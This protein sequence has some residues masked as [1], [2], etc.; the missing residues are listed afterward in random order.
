MSRSTPE[1]LQTILD[2]FPHTLCACI[3]SNKN[4]TIA[5]HNERVATFFQDIDMNIKGKS[6]PNLLKKMGAHHT[7]FFLSNPPDGEART[8]SLPGRSFIA[9]KKTLRTNDFGLD[10]ASN[11]YLFFWGEIPYQQGEKYELLLH[12]FEILLDS[13]HD[14]VWIIDGH[15]MTLH[16]NKALNRIAGINAKNVVGK[17]VT[18]PM[19]EGKFT[20]CVTLDAL[21]QKKTVTQF[22]DYSNGNR[23]LNTSVPILDENGEVRRVVASIRDMSELETLQAKMIRAEMEAIRYKAG[24]ENQGQMD[25]YLGSSAIYKDCLKQ[26]AQVAKSTSCVLLTGE[27]GTGKSMA[28]GY[29]HKKSD[30]NGKAFISINCAAIPESLMDSELFGYQKGAFTGADQGGK[31]G[32][33]ELADGGTLLLDEV[34]ELPLSV[35]A[36]LLHVLDNFSF[37]KVG[38]SAQVSVDVRIVAASN[39]PLAKLVKNG[40]FRQD[41]YYRLHILTVQMPS[42]R[43]RM[44]DIAELA[45]SFL[46]DACRRLG[47]AKLFSPKALLALTTHTWPG[48]VR[49]LRG[50]VEYLAAMTE[51]NTIRVE[52]LRPH[53][54]P[55]KMDEGG[56]VTVRKS[57]TT[58][59]HELEHTML[60]EAIIEEGS[61]YKAAKRLGIS[62]SSVVRKARSLGIR[63]SSHSD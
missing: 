55:D 14:G 30:R 62:Q 50:A 41:L 10:I 48:N 17:H 16:V 35:Q 37:H 43:D 45:N 47:T 54:L 51:G 60:K 6:L 1:I 24:V 15:G 12:E 20:T 11:L 5:V 44:E 34:G 46:D 13:L 53:V 9:F 28:A 38:G 31:K 4:G 36:K 49:E 7:D 23:C 42:L 57:L 22:D 25:G 19:M 61:T 32:Y 26:L 59:V 27:T 63:I 2:F 8:F 52:H 40:E 29:I 18:V 58:A 21:K 3:L 33:F 56:V 39:R